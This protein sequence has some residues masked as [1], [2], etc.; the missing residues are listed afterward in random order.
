MEL[1]PQAFAQAEP[2]SAPAAAAPPAP[3]APA[4]APTAPASPAPPQTQAGQTAPG[5]GDPNAQQLSL[6]DLAGQLVPIFVIM[7]IVY[8]I[9]IRPKA[10]REKEQ[11]AALRNVRRGD[12]LVT[13]S[14]FIGK[15][16][17]AID[18]NEIE[19]ELGP[20][21]RVRMLRSAIVEVRAKGEPV[22]DQAGAKS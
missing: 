12:T 21:V 1:I 11:Q 7:A 10:R 2:P 3:E 15:V 18:D 6:P 19:V 16:A 17:K 9:V 8:V 20:N 22:K 14:G 13:S 4:P 5:G